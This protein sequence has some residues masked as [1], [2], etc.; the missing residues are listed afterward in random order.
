MLLGVVATRIFKLPAW[1]TPALCFNNTTALPLLLI[2]ALNSTGILAQLTRGPDDTASA[3]LARAQS[4]LLVNSIVGNCLTFALGPKLLDSEH[5]PDDPDPA[6]PKSNPSSRSRSPSPSASHSPTPNS[7]PDEQTS[8]LPAFV[9]ERERTL[10]AASN[11]TDR[12]IWARIPPAL[13]PL[14]SLLYAFLNA[15]LIGAV[16]GAVLGLTPPLH[17]AFFSPPDSGGFFTAWLTTSIKNIGAL[18]ASLQVLVVGVNLSES[19]RKARRGED[20]GHVP[21]A[22]A[23]FVVLVR[24]VLWPAVSI[25]VIWAIAEKRRGWVSDD[26]MLWFTL[27][28]MPT[29][30]PAM[31]LAALADVNGSAESEKM[32][33]AKFLTV[34]PFLLLLLQC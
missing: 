23:L 21:W 22:S 16:I 5:A 20:S 32:A 11:R 4:Y 28:M 31:K 7:D 24:F 2:Q 33:I 3:A 27:M 13:H 30:P 6:D 9:V 1:V 17:R 29:G 19:L 25:P 26:P 15:P 34:G 14:L 10:R 12:K 8:L 18:F